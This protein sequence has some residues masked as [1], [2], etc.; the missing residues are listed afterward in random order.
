MYFVPLKAKATSKSQK[1]PLKSF[2]IANYIHT[3]VCKSLCKICICCSF[4]ILYRFINTVNVQS[5]NKKRSV[6]RLV[7][8]WF[9]PSA[10]TVRN[11]HLYVS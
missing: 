4:E 9:A 11:R 10:G 1:Y 2:C 7:F 6:R 5:S 3:N 8:D